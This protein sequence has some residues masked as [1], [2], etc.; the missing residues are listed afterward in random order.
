MR[1]LIERAVAPYGYE[2]ARTSPA[3]VP[4]PAGF[5]S[6]PRDRREPFS[7]AEYDI[8][9]LGRYDIIERTYY[10]PI[11]DL[12]NIPEE[13]WW[14]RGELPGVVFDVERAMA[15]LERDLA[16]YV[17]ELELPTSDPGRPGVYYLRNSGFESVDAELLYAMVRLLRPRRVVELGSGWSTVLIGMAAERNERGGAPIEQV[18]YDP[19]P[20]PHIL[21]DPPPARVE[22][23]PAT[24]VPLAVFTALGPRDVLFVDT[25]HTVKVGGDV[26]HLVLE[27]LPRLRGGVVVHF[28]DIFLPWEYPRSW[29]V[30]DRRYWCEQYLLQ[31]FLAL[32]EHFEVIVPAAALARDFPERLARVVASFGDGVWPGSLWLRRREDAA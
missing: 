29:V 25:T 18:A 27:V 2:L 21:G 17:A 5:E 30:E 10:S 6:I 12:A 23:I 3:V 31:A 20:R 24:E 22:P 1:R 9:P 7:T 32:N 15:F 13:V 8:V 16:G 4:A 11:P 19:Y 26:N 14:R 28:H